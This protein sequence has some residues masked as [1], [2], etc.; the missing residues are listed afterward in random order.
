MLNTDVFS[1][2]TA[3]GE[4]EEPDGRQPGRR[5]GARSSARTARRI[6]YGREKK[7][8]GWPDQTRLAVL[9]LATRRTRRAHRGL[10]ELGRGLDLDRRRR[11]ARLP[12]RG[13]RAHQPLRDSGRWRRRRARCYRGGTTVGRGL[14]SDGRVVFQPPLDDAAARAGRGAPRRQRISGALTHV[15][16]ELVLAID[17][18]AVEEHDVSRARAETTVQMFVVFPPGFE[19]R[20]EVPARPPGPRRAGRHLRRRVQLPL[21]P[22]RLR[23]PRLRR[24]HGELPRLLE[25]RPGLGRVDPR[26]RIRTS[27]SPT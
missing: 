12:R 11:D 15:N 13:A 17:L 4:V 19:P 10:G 23:G 21:E 2:P 9:D 6:A 7:A 25:L 3:G 22:A 20:A 1:V 26:A 5:R 27:R 14:A 16:D 24:G 8:D 18:G